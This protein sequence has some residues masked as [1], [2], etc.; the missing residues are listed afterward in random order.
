MPGGSAG[1]SR[2]WTIR[3]CVVHVHD[4]KTGR[5]HARDLEA[6]DR[7]VGVLLH[8][9]LEHQLVVHL[10]DVVAGQHDHELGMIGLDD[11]DVLEHGVGGPFIPLRL[12]HALAGRQDVE[13]FVALGAQ[14]V[15]AALQV[16]D[17][18]VRLVLR[19]HADAADAGVDRVRQ[20][21]VDDARLATEVD[22][23][24]RPTVGQLV[25][26]GA[27]PPGQHVGHG[28]SGDD[29]T[30][31]GVGHVGVALTRLGSGG[32]GGA[33]GLTVAGVQRVP[34][35]LHVHRSRRKVAA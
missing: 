21:E 25:Q 10:V 19:R 1:F 35:T 18:A 9:L 6:P 27:A 13:A 31:L 24:L 11:V 12:A 3:S 32:D 33:S 16:T 20:R 17:E 28:V 26:P 5:V 14:E 22:G 30:A 29:A 23:R 8:V 15:P 7:H 4:A 34:C 2:K